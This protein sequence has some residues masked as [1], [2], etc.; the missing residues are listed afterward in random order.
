[1][2]LEKYVQHATSLQALC[3]GLLYDGHDDLV[4][5]LKDNIEDS[6]DNPQQQQQQRVLVVCCFVIIY[7]LV[8]KIVFV[9]CKCIVL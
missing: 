2:L 5:R 3:A 1:M 4:E 9:V 7:M 6:I 8:I